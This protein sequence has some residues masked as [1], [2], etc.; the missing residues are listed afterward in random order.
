MLSQKDKDWILEAITAS[1]GRVS[2]RLDGVEGRLGAVEKGLQEVKG[3]LADLKS[4]PP[5]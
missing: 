1:E 2:A 3:E 5:A 4:L